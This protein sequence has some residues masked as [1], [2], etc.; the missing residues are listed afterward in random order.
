[1]PLVIMCGFPCSGKS[2][3]AQELV[4]HLTSEGK[5]VILIGDDTLGIDK[6]A[7]YASSIAEKQARGN[8]KSAVDRA[9]N[10]DTV[11]IVDS[12]NYI[13]GYRYELYCLARALKTPHCVIHCMTRDETCLEWHTKAGE[14]YGKDVVSALFLRFEAP[15]GRN[16]WDKPLFALDVDDDM[17][18]EQIKTAL[19]NPSRPIIPHQA[20]Q[21]QPLSETNFLYELDHRTQQVVTALLQRMG[22]ALPGDKLAVPNAEAKVQLK[23][24]ATMS[25]LRRIRQAFI[26]Y[27]KAHP[28]SDVTVIEQLFVQ[29]INNQL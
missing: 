3:R 22:S 2:T 28:V 29:F 24:K 12:L 10:K 19:F 4:E 5:Q 11:V 17:P 20:T 25:E 21:S 18:Y 8:L 16:R 13:K 26:S 9:L 23:K 7:T 14:P 15:D 1:M 6:A 27:T